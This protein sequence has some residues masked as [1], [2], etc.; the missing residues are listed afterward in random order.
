MTPNSV[1]ASEAMR[2]YAPTVGAVLLLIGNHWMMH[3]GQFVPVRRKL[4]RPPL[5]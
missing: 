2:D 1:A 5:F 4:G 3:A